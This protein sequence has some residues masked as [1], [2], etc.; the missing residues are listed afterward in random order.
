MQVHQRPIRSPIGRQA[1]KAATAAEAARKPIERVVDPAGC[2]NGR[3]SSLDREGQM[4]SKCERRAVQGGKTGGSWRRG[5]GR[6]GGQRTIEQTCST[7]QLE[8]G[9]GQKRRRESGR[10]EARFSPPSRAVPIPTSLPTHLRRRKIFFSPSLP[11][12][13]SHEVNPPT[14]RQ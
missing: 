14:R 12:H 10:E 13:L 3:Q 9:G 11:S 8:D 2:G 7:S 4:T 1:A 6:E 5:R